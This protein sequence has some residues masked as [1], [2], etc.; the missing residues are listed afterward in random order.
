MAFN[1]ETSYKTFKDNYET[2]DKYGEGIPER[3]KVRTILE[4]IRT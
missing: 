4:K 2:M 3:G 1:F